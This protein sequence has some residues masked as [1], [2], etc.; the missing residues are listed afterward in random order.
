MHV[1]DFRN[2]F[3]CYRHAAVYLSSIDWTKFFS[4]DQVLQP[5]KTSTASFCD[6]CVDSFHKLTM[7]NGSCQ[8]LL[9]WSVKSVWTLPHL[10][11]VIYPSC[12]FQLITSPKTANHIWHEIVH[13]KTWS[14]S[15]YRRARRR[16]AF[17]SSLYSIKD[18]FDR[19][20][21]EW[22]TVHQ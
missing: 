20:P 2:F 13:S 11:H 9:C 5:N 21:L 18:S 8:C 19:V 17:T 12:K 10:S 15:P 1:A 6:L 14:L 3:V 4:S 16:A 22:K 7:Q